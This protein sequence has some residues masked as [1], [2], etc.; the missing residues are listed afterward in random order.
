MGVR[1]ELE[2]QAERTTLNKLSFLSL[3]PG[4]FK[5]SCLG[6]LKYKRRKV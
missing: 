4:T 2:A 5:A 1:M 3:T 6:G